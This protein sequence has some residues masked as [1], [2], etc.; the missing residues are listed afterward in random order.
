LNITTVP[1][2]EATKEKP[3]AQEQLLRI[4]LNVNQVIVP[5]RVTNDSGLMVNGLTSDNFT[6][7]ENGVQQPMNF[8]TSDPFALSAAVIFDLSMPD[9]AVQKVNQTFPA[10]EGAFSQF[11][12][13][14]LYT[15]SQSVARI[16]DFAGVGRK[17]TA[18]L[19]DLQYVR[20]RNNG[21]PTLDGPFGP[22]GPTINNEPIDPNVPRVMVP[23]KESH[24]LNDAILRAAIDLSKRDKARRKVIFVISEGREYRSQA[25]YQDVLRV[26]LSN[27]IMV[28]GIG[29]GSAAVPVYGKLEKLHLPKMG[30]GDILPK[31]ANAT[32]GEILDEFSS[33]AIGSAYARVL[34]DARNQ[35][36]LGYMA[37]GGSTA[38]R[39]IEVVVHRPDLK[40]YAKDG[41]YPLPPPRQVQ[42]SQP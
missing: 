31:Y 13:V 21:P 5:V 10:L 26:L 15:F 37:H 29:V 32:G 9:S 23:P 27:N 34:G 3:G 30:Y 41:Y 8:F 42:Q 25:S 40:V 16:T 11:D 18:A 33:S 24:V 38:Y 2:G 4:V 1:E 19:N 20:G 7:F 39:Q 17:L 28:Y 22:Q 14:S 36:T 12:E 35:Y 6:V